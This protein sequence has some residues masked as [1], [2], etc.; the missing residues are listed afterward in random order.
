M[1]VLSSRPIGGRVYYDGNGSAPAGNVL[2]AVLQSDGA[3]ASAS[4]ADFFIV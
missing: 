4:A 1:T 2:V 3:A